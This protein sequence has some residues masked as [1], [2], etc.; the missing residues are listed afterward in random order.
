MKLLL[1]RHAQSIMNAEYRWAGSADPPLSANGIEAVRQLAPQLQELGVTSLFSSSLV[2]AVQTAHLLN[3]YLHVRYHA[4]VTEFND[5][6]IGYW[7]GLTYEELQ[8]SYPEE[9][10]AWTSGASREIPGAESWG[11][12]CARALHGL[13]IIRQRC[14]PSDVAVAVS[15][16]Q[17]LTAI[18]DSLGFSSTKQHNLEGHWLEIVEGSVVYLEAFSLAR[19]HHHYSE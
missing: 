13:D 7:T 18:C 3:E 5:R 19:A 12:L 9:L 1:L 6:D 14:Q 4:P 10:R 8:E 15:H 2:R 17:V 11:A 16:A